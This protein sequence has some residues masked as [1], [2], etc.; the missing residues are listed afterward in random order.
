MTRPISHEGRTMKEV[1][2]RI[3]RDDGR[4]FIIDNKR[5]M[6]PDDG[7]ENWTN[8]PHDIST[9]ENAGYDGGV[10]TNRR[11]S[12]ADRSVRAVLS[13]YRENETARA[14]A[15]AFFSP[16]HEYEAHLTYGG[17]TRWCAGVQY[18]FK[19]STGNVY[20]P[21]QIDWTILSSMP[22]LLSEDD[23]GQDVA[24]V[25]PKYGFQY[26][27]AMD[28]VGK[29]SL[30]FHQ[31]GFV[32]GAYNFNRV[33]KILNDGDMETYPRVIIKAKGNVKNPKIMINGAFIRVVTDMKEGQRLE[34]DLE[35]RPPT[36]R[37]DWA[38]VMHLLDRDSTFTGM[39]FRVG[40]NS[41]SYDADEGENVMSVSLFYRKRYLGI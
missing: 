24:L 16:L 39:R 17:R 31:K 40:E 26:M 21:V 33:V 37:L 13:D 38:S 12:T 2:V 30:L 23:F 10:I 22:F 8:L 14:E 41:F 28:R 32:T 19:C 1:S 18:A 36:V 11:I 7:L 4:E 3:V 20:E 5:W 27:S 25:T 15:I 9:Q 6:I 29:D 35:S 34:I